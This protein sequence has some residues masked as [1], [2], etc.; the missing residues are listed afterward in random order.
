MRP[1]F[2]R[3]TSIKSGDVLQVNESTLFPDGA[4]NIGEEKVGREVD[5]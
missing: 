3:F 5:V 1:A 4:R 2:R